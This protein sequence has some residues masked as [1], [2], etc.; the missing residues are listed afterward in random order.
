MT[1]AR[2]TPPQLCSGPA[3]FLPAA[4]APTALET[5]GA[6]SYLTERNLPHGSIQMPSSTSPDEEVGLETCVL[7]F[8]DL[9]LKESNLINPS[10]SLKA[11]LDA[12]TKKKYS[13]AKKKAF[14]LFVKTKQVPAPSLEFKGKWWRC[15][16]QLFADQTSI[17]R[18][19]ATQH[20]E[21][22]CQQTASVLKQLTA[23]PSASQS[24]PSADRKSP[25][26]DCRPPSQEVSAWLPDVSRI[27]PDEL[28]SGQGDEDGEVLLYYCYC[29]LEDPHRICAWQTALCQLLHLTGKIRI[30]TEGINGTVGGS[31]VATRLY[32]EAMLSC[33][34][35]KDYLCE[36][37]FKSSKGG[38]HCFPDLRVGVF[39][40]IV[41]MGVSP[42]QISYKNPGIH[43]SPGEFHKEIEKL[44]SQANQDRGDTILLDCRNFYES[45]IGVCKEVFQ[46]KGGIHK[47]LE[48]FPEGFYKGKLFVFDERFALAYNSSVVAE[49]SYCGAP[50]DQYKLCSTPQCR[51]LVLTCS[52]CQG[53]GF[54]ACCVTCQDKGGRQA[55]GPTQDSFK[56][57]CECTARRPRIPQEQRA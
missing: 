31:K 52:A 49:C 47:Y 34:L 25:P 50:W 57:E 19:V 39:E 23:A 3:V 28:S 22:V 53:Q 15:C 33:P 24:L 10:N 40:E 9:D 7:K 55:S 21:E 38:A 2:T 29:D 30:A 1:P 16:Q 46:L 36:E 27:S 12:N 20:A 48:E 5:S 17:H 43:L 56:E 54:T 44:L 6:R 42:S 51:Q 32:V 14:A 11:E 41:P 13:F 35:F 45:K 4:P 26:K 8:S 37:D 18:H